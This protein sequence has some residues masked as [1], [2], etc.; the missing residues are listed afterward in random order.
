M[1]MISLQGK[2]NFFEKRVSD[3]ARAHINHSSPEI[4]AMHTHRILYVIVVILSKVCTDRWSV[5]Q[6][7]TSSMRGQQLSH[8]HYIE[9]RNLYVTMLL[10]HYCVL[11]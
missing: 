7:M 2:A 11:L 4:A 3:Y 9:H 1:E 8:R 6:K 5:L 10:Q